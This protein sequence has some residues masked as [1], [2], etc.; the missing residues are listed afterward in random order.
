MAA[1][2]GPH[3]PISEF[4]T[5]RAPKRFL[6][7][8]RMLW[9]TMVV[10]F[11]LASV[12]CR[13]DDDAAPRRAL[14]RAVGSDKDPA[15]NMSVWWLHFPK[16]G[17]SLARSVLE[18]PLCCGRMVGLENQPLSR[19]GVPGQRESVVAIFREPRQRILSSYYW[20]KRKSGRCCGWDWGWTN[21][22]SDDLKRKIRA[23]ASPRSTVAHFKGCMTAM[24]TGGK[25]MAGARLSA[26]DAAEAAARVADFKVVGLVDHWHESVCLLNYLQTGT[27]FVTEAAL[28]YGS[29]ATNATTGVQTVYDADELGADYVD[30]ADDALYA[31]ARR[32]FFAQVRDHGISL[33]ACPAVSDETA[34]RAIDAA[35]L[36]RDRAFAAKRLAGLSTEMRMVERI[37][38]RNRSAA[39]ACQMNPR[40]CRS[41]FDRHRDDNPPESELQAKLARLR[42]RHAWLGTQLGGDE[43]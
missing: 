34:D 9:I 41:G 7:V 42:L 20:L 15:S 6:K 11:G 17:T 23:G 16:C 21:S 3:H 43:A 40:R 36:A 12:A 33:D 28:S 29:S 30:G 39:A 4:L 10:L 38:E 32:R 25:C 13:V 35:A 27:R 22:V 18:Y 19:D 14:R 37:V 8:E 31:V 24:V 2:H 1:T 5:K 26:A